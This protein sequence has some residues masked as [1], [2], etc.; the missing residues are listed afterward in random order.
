L[1]GIVVYSDLGLE[2]VDLA[3]VANSSVESKKGK[4]EIEMRAVAVKPQM[5]VLGPK[6]KDKSGRI[7]KALLAMD[8]SEVAEQKAAGSISV[9]LDKETFEVAPEAVE[10][11][12]ETLS[13]GEAVDVLKVGEATVLVRR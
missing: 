3:G 12:T 1:P 4:P 13:A 8:P 6:F 7:V 5:K 9:M 10:I 11:V 2:T